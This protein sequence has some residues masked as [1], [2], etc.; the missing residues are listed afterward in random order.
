MPFIVV[1][2]LVKTF[3]SGSVRALDGVSLTVD[4]GEAVGIIGPNGAGK[5]TLFGCLLGFLRPQAGRIV[6][7]GRAPDDLTNRAATGY[8]PERLVMDR[9]MNGLEFLE[10]HHA[11]AR[12]PS[13]RRADECRA[14]LERVGLDREAWGKAIR[15]YSRGMLQRLG[16]AQALLGDPRLLFLDEPISGVD[17]SGVLLFRRLLAE[18]RARG[19][20][21]LVNSHQLGEVERVCDRVVFV[22]RGRVAALQTLAVG[23]ALARA[24]RVRFAAAAAPERAALE[25][26]ARTAG[27]ELLGLAAPDAHFRVADDAGATRLLAAL[28]A[29]GLPVIE[30]VAEEGRLERLFTQAGTGARP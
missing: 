13:A 1:D 12:L 23:A 15:S 16:L 25:E 11:L 9:W 7:D 2:N 26:T 18:Q 22:D 6:I 28:L 30:A 8:L 29:A 19:A 3:R 17:P 10:H 21:L 24:L 5:T 4:P 14:A 27:A 20:T